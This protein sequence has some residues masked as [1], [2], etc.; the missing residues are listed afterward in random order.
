MIERAAAARNA[1]ISGYHA[2]QASVDVAASCR[3]TEP[4]LTMIVDVSTLGT[5]VEQRSAVVEESPWWCWGAKRFEDDATTFS[6]PLHL[7]KNL[8]QGIPAKMRGPAAAPAA[9][10]AKPRSPLLT[11][12]AAANA[13]AKI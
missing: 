3:H 13:E 5:D 1:G 8:Q 2:D 12:P 11:G 10:D 6:K 9:A 4:D 7:A